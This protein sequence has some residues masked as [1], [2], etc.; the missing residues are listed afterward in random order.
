MMK[1]FIA[2]V[3]QNEDGTWKE[4]QSLKEHLEAV[5]QL[6]GK[7]AAEFGNKDWAELAGI[8]ARSW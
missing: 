1:E 2:H 3:K 7:F 8:S 4:P 6:A 5:A